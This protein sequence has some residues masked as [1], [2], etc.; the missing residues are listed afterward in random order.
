MWRLPGALDAT[1]REG[2]VQLLD[3]ICRLGLRLLGRSHYLDVPFPNVLFVQGSFDNSVLCSA[4]LRDDG[5]VALLA[6]VYL[7]KDVRD[8]FRSAHRGDNVLV[9]N[10]RRYADRSLRSFLWLALYNRIGLCFW[11]IQWFCVKI[12]RGHVPR[13]CSFWLGFTMRMLCYPFHLGKLKYA[14]PRG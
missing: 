2:L 14:P 3:A 10:T 1:R 11:G 8:T 13:L 9:A 6:N 5:R 4:C 7:S 12:D